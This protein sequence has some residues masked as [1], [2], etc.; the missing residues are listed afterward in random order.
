MNDATQ[1]DPA[2][3]REFLHGTLER[4]RKTQPDFYPFIMREV[5]AADPT[6][7]L[8]GTL[9]DWA[10]AFSSIG[11]SVSGLITKAADVAATAYGTKVQAD[12]QATIAK[13]NAKAQIDA[14]NSNIQVQAAQAQ[15]AFQQQQLL[16]QQQNLLKQGSAFST[17]SPTMLYVVGGAALLGIVFMLTKPPRAA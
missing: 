17:G 10:D 1:L 5:H 7:Q 11:N 8:N 16:Q 13:A 9:G 6:F 12:A 4:I 2:L 15:N 14:M 3:A